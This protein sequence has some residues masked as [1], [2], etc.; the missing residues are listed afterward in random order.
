MILLF[1]LWSECLLQ[2]DKERGRGKTTIFF[3]TTVIN[4]TTS[5]SYNVM[6]FIL[7]SDNSSSYLIND[8][9]SSLRRNDSI[10]YKEQRQC[11][12]KV[13]SL[14]VTTITKFTNVS[15]IEN[16]IISNRR[17]K[18]EQ[19]IRSRNEISLEMKQRENDSVS[20]KHRK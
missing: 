6:K 15:G 16:D 8:I 7:P 3:E 4:E 19:R 1:A 2:R 13:N 11:H 14:I 12:I 18:V 20:W 5:F 9:K 10:S 17:Q